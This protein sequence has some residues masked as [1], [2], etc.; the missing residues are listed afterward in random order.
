MNGWLSMRM[1]PICSDGGAEARVT[2]QEV[3]R[4]CKGD[5]EIVVCGGCGVWGLW[6]VGVVVCGGC[7]VWGLWC[8]GVV[9]CGGCGAWGLWCVE[10][11]VCGGCGVWGLWC[12]G[13]VVRGGCGV[14][15]L[16]CVGVVVPGSYSVCPNARR[17]SW[18]QE[19]TSSDTRLRMFL[20]ATSSFRMTLM[21]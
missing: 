13:V 2:L 3:K 16:W 8:V 7:G 15:G 18:T 20:R 9:V 1:M 4:V 21:A 12:V 19:H 6:C 17:P 14:W 5:T 10:V 11:V